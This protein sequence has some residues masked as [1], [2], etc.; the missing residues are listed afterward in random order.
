MLE[1]ATGIKN[2]E[3]ERGTSVLTSL[4]LTFLV[5]ISTLLSNRPTNKQIN[6]YTHKCL[7]KIIMSE[8]ESS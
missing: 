3:A 5:F 6:Q 1:D 4:N 2:S 7:L 8:E